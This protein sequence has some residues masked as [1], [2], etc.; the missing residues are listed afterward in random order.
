MFVLVYSQMKW[1]RR[2]SPNSGIIVWLQRRLFLS[3]TPAFISV[4][5]FHL[6]WPMCSFD[7]PLLYVR[8]H[9]DFSLGYRRQHSSYQMLSDNNI[10][11]FLYAMNIKSAVISHW[12]TPR[13]VMWLATCLRLY[14]FC[15]HLW[16]E[17][18]AVKSVFYGF[19]HGNSHPD[20]YCNWNLN[21]F[22]V[23]LV[24]FH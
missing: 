7:F 6:C 19:T 20:S 9:M 8:C 22:T 1:G 3:A 11:L 15:S 14:Y 10:L 16:A 5:H 23:T 13:E 12:Q 21:H 24:L 2:Y 17:D 18:V 4:L